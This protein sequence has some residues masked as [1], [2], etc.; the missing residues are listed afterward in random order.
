MKLRRKAWQEAKNFLGLPEKCR[1]RGKIRARK[2]GLGGSV[3]EGH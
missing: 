1:A 2:E 3:E